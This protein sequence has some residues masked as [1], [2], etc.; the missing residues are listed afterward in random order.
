MAKNRYALLMA[1]ILFAALLTGCTSQGTPIQ[2]PP[3]E[4]T[5]VAEP[6]QPEETVE[7]LTATATM[8]ENS[9]LIELDLVVTA[10]GGVEPYTY[11]WQAQWIVEMTDDDVEWSDWEDEPRATDA[12][13]TIPISDGI[14]YRCIVTDSAG[15]SVIVSPK[16]SSNEPEEPQETASSDQ[17][18]WARAYV[19]FII[20]DTQDDIKLRDEGASYM[21]LYLDGDEIPELYIDYGFTYAGAKICTWDGKQVNFEY[22]GASDYLTY[23]E[24]ENC[25]H[26]RGGRMDVYYDVIYQIKNGA[27]QEKARGDRE[28][29]SYDP[30]EIRYS[31]NGENVSEN[32]YN[33][34][35]AAV[36]DESK[37]KDAWKET[38]YNF[39]EICDKLS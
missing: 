8:E 5:S 13:Y 18:P 34:A 30:E 25:F 14:Q 19:D 39:Y 3:A 17:E 29:L 26:T 4:D 28:V 11:Q 21:L 7:P 6:E 35:L 22:T 31:W 2:E 1:G 37:A 32:Q 15:N 33:A 24:K 10:S 16:F 23:Y 38:N 9:S 20:Q 12:V 36:F 27:I